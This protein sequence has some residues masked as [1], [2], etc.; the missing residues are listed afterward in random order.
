MIDIAALIIKFASE[1][2]FKNVVKTV[3]HGNKSDLQ[4]AYQKAFANAVDFYEYEYGDRYGE[5][6]NRFFDYRENEEQLATLIFIRQKPDIDF[7]EK[8]FELKTGIA[9]PDEVLLGFIKK[10]HYELRQF[11]ECE[12]ILIEKDKYHALMEMADDIKIIRKHFVKEET[13]EQSKPLYWKSLFEAFKTR[14]LHIISIKHVGGGLLGPEELPLEEVFFE[15]DAGERRLSFRKDT[16][17]RQKGAGDFADLF[18]EMTVCEG[19][20]WRSLQERQINSSRVKQLTSEIEKENIHKIASEFAAKYNE[21]S[22]VVDNKQFQQIIEQ[23]AKK[24]ELASIRVIAAL[25]LFF[26][27]S[28]KREPV[29][30]VLKP[31]CSAFVIGDAGVGKTTVM[32]MLS[33]KLF[34]RFEAGEENVPLPLFVR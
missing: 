24:F 7:I 12:D 13:K 6:G 34:K 22:S 31:P 4:K 26:T 17:G 15:Q 5:K 19:H 21:R 10:L 2:A 27:E 9:I 20:I 25:S 1:Q 3:F 30:E 28:M 11:R 16:T 23:I 8:H 14:Q 18:V 32:R 33:L 29:L